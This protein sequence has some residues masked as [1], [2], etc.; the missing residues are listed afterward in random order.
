[1]V[2]Q[3]DETTKS[4]LGDLREELARRVTPLACVEE[5]VVAGQDD[6]GDENDDETQGTSFWWG[7]FGRVQSTGNWIRDEW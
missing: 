1:M 3:R 7:I 2:P 6:W 5:S 4:L